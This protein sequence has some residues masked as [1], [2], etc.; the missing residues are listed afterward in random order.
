MSAEFSLPRLLG[1]KPG[2][3]ILI[4]NAPEGYVEKLR[5]AGLPKTMPI[6]TSVAGATR[7]H[8]VQGFVY[9]KADVEQVART[10]IGAVTAGGT[11]WLTYPKKSMKL[12][13]DLT[14]D[15]GWAAVSELGWGAVSNF[16]VDK[17]WTA[18]LFTP[19]GIKGGRR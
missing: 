2:N 13:T 11:V 6:A 10:A 19:G 3:S 5:A 17:T 12:D 8:V 7:Y 16:A 14:R 15:D 18:K 1:I 4:L 9:R